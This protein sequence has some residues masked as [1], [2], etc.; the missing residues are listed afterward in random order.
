MSLRYVR[1]ATVGDVAPG[2]FARV[3]PERGEYVLL[4]NL[5][6]A[7]YA[8]RDACSHDG[9]ILGFGS[10]EGNLIECPRHGAKF[11]VATGQVVA[12]PATRPIRTYAVRVQDDGIEIGLEG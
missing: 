1:V 3:T 5:D 11:D 12:P 6:G 9:G 8:I 2:E 10:L 4:C 7:Y